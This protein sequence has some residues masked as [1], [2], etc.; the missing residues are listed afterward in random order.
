MSEKGRPVSERLASEV[1]LS[2]PCGRVAE[3]S[4]NSN[5]LYPGITPP[6]T[7]SLLTP[8]IASPIRSHLGSPP[9]P[10]WSFGGTNVDSLEI[11]TEVCRASGDWDIMSIVQQIGAGGQPAKARHTALARYPTGLTRR[12]V[13]P[14]RLP[15]QTKLVEYEPGF[16][17]LLFLTTSPWGPSTTGTAA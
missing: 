13:S 14:E 3:K 6:A 12:S 5:M 16:L 17:F 8:A 7:A 9:V 2:C 1:F 4:E 15:C 11:G 10:C